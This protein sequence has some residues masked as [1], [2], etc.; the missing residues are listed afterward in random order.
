MCDLLFLCNERQLHNTAISPSFLSSFFPSFLPSFFPSFL[1][2]FFPSQQCHQY[3]CHVP[4]MFATFHHPY[5]SQFIR[6]DYQHS[7]YLDCSRAHFNTLIFC[8]L[9]VRA[10]FTAL[11]RMYFLI[12]TLSV[13][14]H[15][16]SRK[17]PVFW[18]D[19]DSKDTETVRYPYILLMTE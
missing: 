3:F 12:R 10:Y 7:S 5:F 14:T 16:R 2:S 17:V 1:P 15:F 19:S 13:R 9:T 6:I 18:E 8:I 11:I 4:P